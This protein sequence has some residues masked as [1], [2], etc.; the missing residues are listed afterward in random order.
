MTCDRGVGETPGGEAP[1]SWDWICT[2]IKLDTAGPPWVRK[3]H[4]FLLMTCH[5]RNKDGGSPISR[6]SV[7]V[8]QPHAPNWEGASEHRRFDQI[9]DL[10]N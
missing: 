8:Y 5:S 3:K 7:G 10:T 6:T 1:G 4:D 9:V 2:S